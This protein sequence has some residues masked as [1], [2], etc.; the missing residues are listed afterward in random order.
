M[1]PSKS[2]RPQKYSQDG[3]FA[4]P[5]A[6]ADRCIGTTTS[7]T[8]R[9]RRA[10]IRSATTHLGCAGTGMADSVSCAQ[11]VGRAHCSIRFVARGERAHGC[12][13]ARRLTTA[14]LPGTTTQGARSTIMNPAMYPIF[15]TLQFLHAIMQVQA[16][17]SARLRPAARHSTSGANNSV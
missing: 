11:L 15:A 6:R 7:Y 1:P 2:R 8:E 5:K 4:P 12:P 10:V 3:A 17:F 9:I 14:A 16:G 13:V